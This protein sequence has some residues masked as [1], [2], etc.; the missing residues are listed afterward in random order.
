MMI[1]YIIY[2]VIDM[3]IKDLNDWVKSLPEITLSG[4]KMN[5]FLPEVPSFAANE[6]I[7]NKGE[8]KMFPILY[9]CKIENIKIN[10]VL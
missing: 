4:L 8:S 6:R 5:S 3:D 10:I 7:L 1:M 2:S 9:I